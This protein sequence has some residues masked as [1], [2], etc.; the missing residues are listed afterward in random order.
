MEIFKDIIISIISIIVI[1]KGAIML[2]DSAV[3]I[4]QRFGISELIIGLTIVAMGTSAPEFAVTIISS[5]SGKS[6]ISVGNI[7][8]SNIFNLGFMK[9]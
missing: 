9:F 6:D 7:V 4:A 1:S 8:G 2:V 3:R 5:F